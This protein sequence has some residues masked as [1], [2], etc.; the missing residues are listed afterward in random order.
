[1]DIHRIDLNLLVVLEAIYTEGGLTRA[2]ERLN[3]TQPAISYSLGRLRE[4]LGDPLFVREGHSMVP[5]PF[6]RNTIEPLQHALRSVETM[7]NDMH[8]FEPPTAE[9][10]FTLGCRDVLESRVLPQLMKRI[11]QTAPKIELATVQFNRHNIKTDLFSGRLDV[12]TDVI[13]PKSRHIRYVPLCDDQLAVVARK[14]HPR[15]DGELTL[16]KYLE[17]G[18]VQVSSRPTGPGVEDFELGRRG[19][20]RRVMLRC[21][22]YFAALR[23][24][25][26]TDLIVTIPHRLALIGSQPAGNQILPFPLDMPRHEHYLLWHANMDNDPANRWLREQ[27]IEAF[28]ETEEA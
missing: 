23:V 8:R 10:R 20:Q 14:G 25:S 16:E 3:V 13:L 9:R 24:V 19:M 28:K 7:L 27:I 12:A 1:M 17:L 2:A 18:H 21:Q 26:Q 11:T 22:H 5:T 4:L 6:T 15:L